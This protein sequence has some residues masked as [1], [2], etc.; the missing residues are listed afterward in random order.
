M[1]SLTYFATATVTIA[2]E[3]AV[4]ASFEMLRMIACLEVILQSSKPFFKDLKSTRFCL[5]KLS[6]YVQ[7]NR[8][9]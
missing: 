5:D 4:I 3:A 6:I 8:S 9:V 7:G 1:R 2:R